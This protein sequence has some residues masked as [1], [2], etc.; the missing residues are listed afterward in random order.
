MGKITDMNTRALEN[1]ENYDDAKLN[2]LFDAKEFCTELSNLINS[3]G[4]KIDE[5]L[6]HC[7]ISRSYLMDMKNPP[8]NIQPKRNKILDLCLGINASKEETNTL[9]RLA[10]YQPLDSRGENLDRIIIWGLAQ[11]KNN[12]EIRSKLY[13]YGYTEFLEQ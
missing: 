1:A 7:Y 4:L 10:H 3:K 8:K 12:E 13:E 11:K 9:L 6:D 2:G 5:I